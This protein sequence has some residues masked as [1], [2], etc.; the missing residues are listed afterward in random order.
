MKHKELKINVGCGP[1]GQIQGY[2]N[3]DN[4]PS[5][6][7]SRTPYIKKMLFKLGLISKHQLTANWLDVIRCDASKRLPYNDQSVSKIYTSHFLEHIPYDKAS[8]F[9]QECYRVLKIEG[10]MR[11][12][13]PDLF[14]YA[15]KYV[16]NTKS[17]LNRE[18]LPED[19]NIHDQFIEIIFGAY[20][21]N[22]RYG[23]DHFYMYDLP[24]LISLLRNARFQNIKKFDYKVGD[25]EELP[26]YD[27][28]PEDSLHIEVRK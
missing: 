19:R 15:V 24:T 5:I 25:D 3:L 13:V 14:F 20:L 7:I 28:R 12:V 17:I 27:S 16:E 11:L 6:L 26:N 9:L 18:S 4:S 22:K 21:N 10:V 23:A 2:E 1:T 8:L